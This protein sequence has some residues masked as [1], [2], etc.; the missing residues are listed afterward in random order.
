MEIN[1]ED[2]TV[3]QA[4]NTISRGIQDKV[5]FLVFFVVF[6]TFLFIYSNYRL[7]I[8]ECLLG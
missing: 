2:K 1:E 6:L 3:G 7:S 8:L 4:H 5:L